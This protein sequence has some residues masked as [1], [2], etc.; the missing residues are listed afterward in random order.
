[1][2]NAA[3]LLA[4]IGAIGLVAAFSA[5]GAA[6][7]FSRQELLDR[8]N[9]NY[10]AGRCVDSAMNYYALLQQFSA[11]LGAEVRGKMH[12]RIDQCRRGRV[13]TAGMDGKADTAPRIDT[14]PIVV[15]PERP[16]PHV[17]IRPRQ[18]VIATPLPMAEEDASAP[19]RVRAC[20]SYAE[21]AVTQMRRQATG[22]CGQQ[23]FLWSTDY[24][25]HYDWCMIRATPAAAQDATN[26]RAQ[27][28][29]SCILRW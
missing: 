24:Q 1:M 27:A 11:S 25:A 13:G 16:Q 9:H 22:R 10:K 21:S 29:N 3:L 28:L 6:Q 12:G 20:R 5:P 23:G 7:P 17:A 26:R 14:T 8:G 19:P 2:R 18:V 4:T 15:P